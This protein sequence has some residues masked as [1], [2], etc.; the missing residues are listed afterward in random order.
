MYLH[1]KEVGNNNVFMDD[2]I[3]SYKIENCCLNKSIQ[4]NINL[5]LDFI[6]SLIVLNIFSVLQMLRDF[7]HCMI[8]FVI[9]ESILV[10]EDDK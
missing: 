6:I 5:K 3:K 7:F 8:H 4:I 1:V 2:N 10:S 9:L